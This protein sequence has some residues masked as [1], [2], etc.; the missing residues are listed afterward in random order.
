MSIETA[1]GLADR[2]ALPL[3]ARRARR[4]GLDPVPG[5]ADVTAERVGAAPSGSARTASRT[6]GSCASVLGDLLDERVLRRPRA[7]PGR[8]GHDV[9]AGPAA[10]DE[11]D[12]ARTTAPAPAAGSLTEAFYADPVRRYMLPVFSDRRTD[13][14][15]P[16]AR[17]PRL[18]A[19]ARHVGGRGADPPLPDQGARRAAADL[20]AVLRALHPDG[21]GRQLHPGGRQAEVRRQAG[22][23]AR[24]DDRLPAPH[25]RRCATSSS[26]AATWRTC[27]GRGSRPSSPGCSRSTTSA[28]SGSPPRR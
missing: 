27:R 18:A 21:P 10:D 1:I 17:H 11:H 13:W 12:G 9:D 16:P 5:L 15:S 20:P 26:P 19:R 22:R 6:S 23:P 3:P 14:P 25:A 8:A 7:R 4:A 2:P 24:R 28:T